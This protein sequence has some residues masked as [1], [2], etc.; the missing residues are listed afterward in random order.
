MYVCLCN[1]FTCRDVRKA[2]GEGAS[3]VGGVFRACDARPN[4]GRCKEVIRDYLA[5]AEPAVPALPALL[6]PALVA[7]E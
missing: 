3:S 7:A 1:G 2:I 6:N 5:E 4:C